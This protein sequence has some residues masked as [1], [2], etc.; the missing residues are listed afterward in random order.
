[1]MNSLKYGVLV[2]SWYLQDFEHVKPQIFD[3]CRVLVDQLEVVPYRDKHLIK[4]LWTIT[5]VFDVLRGLL[6]IVGKVF[7]SG[8]TWSTWGT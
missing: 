1:M 5:I 2:R 8:T 7:D 6:P 3:L 4:V